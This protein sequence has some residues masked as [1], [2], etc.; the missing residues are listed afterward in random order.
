MVLAKCLEQQQVCPQRWKILTLK[1]SMIPV[2]CFTQHLKFANTSRQTIPGPL[3]GDGALDAP[4]SQESGYVATTTCFLA[5]GLK[6]RHKAMPR[7][8]GP[9]HAAL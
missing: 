6:P 5:G 2:A 4:N 1:G 8:P 3:Q 9:S 7:V